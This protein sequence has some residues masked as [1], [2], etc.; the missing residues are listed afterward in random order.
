MKFDRA[1]KKE[2]KAEKAFALRSLKAIAPHLGKPLDPASMLDDLAPLIADESLAP[3]IRV[4]GHFLRRL[5]LARLSL[6][7]VN[8]PSRRA[9]VRRTQSFR[10]G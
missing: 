2:R 9:Q 10:P 8:L 4:L 7:R 5:Q 1:M 3:E 6:P